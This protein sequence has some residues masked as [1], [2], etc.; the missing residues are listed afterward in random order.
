MAV[1]IG[2]TVGQNLLISLDS[3]CGLEV[4]DSFCLTYG[5]YSHTLMFDLRCLGQNITFMKTIKASFMFALKEICKR[6]H[7]HSQ[8]EP[9]F[10]G[11]NKAQTT[12]MS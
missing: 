6:C 2:Q 11:S 12:L 9:L 7:V 4:N 1:I 3:Y 8:E 10:W 5:M